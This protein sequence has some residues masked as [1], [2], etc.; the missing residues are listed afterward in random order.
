MIILLTGTTI[1]QPQWFP[2]NS[3]VNNFLSD[4]SFV[5]EDNGWISGSTGIILRT[6]NGGADWEI[7]DPPPNNYYFSIFFTSTANGWAT[8]YDGKIIHTADGGNTWIDQS[9]GTSTYLNNLFFLDDNEGWIV[10]GD[11]GNFPSYIKHRVILHTADGGSTW[12]AQVNQSEKD[13][14]KDV[15]FVS[16]SV[17]Y[18]V[19]ESG[20]ILKTSDGGGTWVSQLEDQSYQFF[21]TCFLN[22][23]EGY[24]GGEYLGLPH[25]SVI[26]KTSDGGNSW[27]S[28]TFGEDETI[29]D[30]FFPDENTGWALGS[31]LTTGF[32]LYSED[33]GVTWEYVDPGT[34]DAL[35]R[36]SFAGNTGWAVGAMGTVTSTNT[37]TGTDEIRP[38]NR[39]NLYP[40]PADD[41]IVVDYPANNNEAVSIQVMN[42]AG[43]RV[44][45]F[46]AFKSPYSRYKLNTSNFIEGVY[47]LRLTR[48]SG[49]TARKFMIRR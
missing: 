12:N 9:S 23:A 10:G 19:G 31:A 43:Q 1:G 24:V 13:P 15:Y 42:I 26:F 28:Q 6:G 21:S 16:A 47:T 37:S 30:L 4:V 5:D 34:T 38:V 33:G 48:Q 32:L 14:L 22:E 27:E 36:F 40:N 25:V 39:I 44:F 18:A 3:G 46:D 17:G 49:T 20:N 2:Q 11:N 45:R 41:Y 35:N 8:G 29:T 7:L